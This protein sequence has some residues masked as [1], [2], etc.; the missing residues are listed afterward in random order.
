MDRDIYCWND[1]SKDRKSDPMVLV[2]RFHQCLDADGLD[3]G[4]IRARLGVADMVKPDDES[5]EARKLLLGGLEAKG[6]LARIGYR[7]F[8]VG[9]LDDDGNGWT[10]S[11]SVE[12]LT[13]F[14]QW[15]AEL[16]KKLAGSPT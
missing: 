5:A 11:E 6:E 3:Y 2:R 1:G 9:P 10:E 4:K 8:D 12:H 15:Q 14:F 7:V 13:H 16:E